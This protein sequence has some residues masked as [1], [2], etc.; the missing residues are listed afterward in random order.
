MSLEIERKFLIKDNSFKLMATSCHH[1]EQ[2]YLSTDRSRTIRVRVKDDIYAY[3]TIKGANTGAIRH[4]WEYEIP[5]ADAREMIELCDGKGINKWRY[6]VP[7]EGH[8]WE[9][10]V[11]EDR[12]AGLVVA[13]VELE[14]EDEDVHIPLFVGEEVTGD[15]RYYNSVLSG[16]DIKPD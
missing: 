1:I 11:F 14:S 4:E 13:E 10:D 9:V 8:I 2:Y 3:L 12:H 16:V 6:I 5:V 15:K 7:W